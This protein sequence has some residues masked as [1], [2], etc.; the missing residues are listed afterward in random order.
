[1]TRLTD[2]GAL[3]AAPASGDLIHIVDISDTSSSAAG[4]SKKI[5][6]DNV[7]NRIRINKNYLINGDFI[8]PQRGITFTAATDVVNNDDTYLL[9]RW[10]LLSDGNDIV[11]VSQETTIVPA[12][13]YASMKVE[14]VTANKKFGFVQIVEARNAAKLIGS[15]ASQAMKAQKVVGNSTLETLR[16]GILA[17]DGAEDAVTSDVVDGSNWN[18]AGT[19]PTLAANWTYENTP[20]DIM[21]TDSWVTTAIENISIDTVSTKNVAVFIWCDDVDA[22]VGDLMYLTDVKFE[23][24]S[25]A[26][27]YVAK[28]AQEELADCQRYFE[29]SYDQASAP[30]ATVANGNVLSYAQDTFTTQC[31][32]QHFKTTKRAVPTITVYSPSTG[33]SGKAYD[34]I[35]A[36]DVNMAGTD[37]GD[38][39]FRYEGTAG[40]LTIGN[41][42]THH[43]TA[44]SEL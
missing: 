19:D 25:V 1:M 36:G 17:W 28:T 27:A 8:V 26:T 20:F 2:K 43:Y 40:S 5:T 30:G 31:N 21:L 18:A 14:V 3:S 42:Y 38:S 22:T 41:Y 24:G 16:V 9:D 37:I 4:T 29:K 32:I 39:Q 12:G 10:V 23:K 11:D 33:A 35:A 34:V 6:I 13:S 15:F 7:A 44:D